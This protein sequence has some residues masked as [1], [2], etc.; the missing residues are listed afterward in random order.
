M[1][2]YIEFQNITKIFPGQKA[3]DDVSFTVKKGEV[4]ALIGENGAG[5]STL[6]NILHGIFPATTG[7][8]FIDSKEVS[9][10][11]ASEAIKY[12]IAKVHQEINVIPELTVAENI[13]LGNELVHGIFLNK[14]R[15]LIETQKILD[16]LG[17][18]FLA[19]EKM[20]TLST[21]KKQMVQIAKA[22]HQKAK[23][24]SFDEPTSSLSNSEVDSL[25]LIIKKLRSEGITIL[26]ISHKL[27]EI[28]AICDRATIL[29]DGKYICNIEL[30][31]ANE[32]MLIQNMVGRDVSMFARR[33]KPSQADYSKKVLEVKDLAGEAGFKDINF[34][35]YQG[36]IL[37]FFGL[38][39]AM[40]TETMRVIFGADK[41]FGGTVTLNGKELN[42]NRTP[43]YSVSQK[44][45]LISENRKEEGFIHN[46]NNAN[47]IILPR[48]KNYQKGLFIDKKEIYE[49]AKKF[50][51]QVGLHPNDP[52]FLTES[53][54]G[55]NVQKVILAKWLA[56]DADI[57]ILDEPT[58]GIDIGAKTEI[59]KLLEGLVESGKSII[60]VSS[61]LTEVM[62]MC[63][64]VVVMR[65][66][67]I[68]ST[69]ER[70]DFSENLI[71]S[72]AVGGNK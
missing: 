54:S 13:M 64:R 17:C 37:G 43:Y 45:G 27:D 69:V 70:E 33:E 44:I 32:G 25:F 7:K 21:G 68:V 19:T 30:D 72:L 58:K 56:I 39:G 5:K 18:N 24:I 60:M 9:F 65:E 16:D 52:D 42:R 62:G 15:M 6:L 14:Q 23:I 71:I 63:D 34:D 67:N 3:L 55:G 31:K 36:E 59:Y 2:K 61:E 20:K 26:Y 66:G 50:G 10:N 4:H 47:N 49:T 40:R 22:L 11:N 51:K 38:V 53:L 29:R 1:E 41:S 46:L 12:G 48:V 28:F 35:L 8:V 57:L